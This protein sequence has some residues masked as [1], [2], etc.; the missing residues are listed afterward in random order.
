MGSPGSRPPRRAAAGALLLAA[1]AAVV[2]LS[3]ATRPPAE[4]D[5]ICAIFEEKP[6]WYKDAR[7]AAG[8]WGVPESV[9]LALIHQESSFRADARPPR[10]WFLF[11]IPG[12]R[13]S[14]A[15]GY[16]QALDSTWRR[17]QRSTGRSW[18]DRDDFGDVA[19]FIGWYAAEARER[20]GVAPSDAYGLYLAYHEGAGGFARSS[21]LEK[22]WL[23]RVARKVE[24]RARRYE[25]QLAGCR[26]RLESPWWWPF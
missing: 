14:T 13:P 25:V 12:P 26:A 7:R 23:L 15:Y 18:A 22:S 8:R 20:A 9:Q 19:D 3:C 1:A 17:Y 6:A 21:H 10:R 5:D 2:A 16:G 11:V 24:S 4:P